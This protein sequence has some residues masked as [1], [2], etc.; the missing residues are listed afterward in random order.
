V[1]TLGQLGDAPATGDPHQRTSSHGYAY[2][3]RLA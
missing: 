3:L 2:G 1:V